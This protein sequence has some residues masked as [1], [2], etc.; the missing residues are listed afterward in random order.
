M[1]DGFLTTEQIDRLARELL[2][3]AMDEFSIAV[4]TVDF[5]RVEKRAGQIE[6]EQWRTAA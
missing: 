6:S 5:E 2:D 3:P 4:G 1:D